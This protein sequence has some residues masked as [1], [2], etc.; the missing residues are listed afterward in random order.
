MANTHR[1]T[2]VLQSIVFRL[3]NC[4]FMLMM[5]IHSKSLF[6]FLLKYILFNCTFKTT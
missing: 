2:Q 3:Q 1:V 4:D 5:V 6:T